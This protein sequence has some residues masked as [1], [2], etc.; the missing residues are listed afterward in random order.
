M[1]LFLKLVPFAMICTAPVLPGGTITLRPKAQNPVG[2]TQ[3][4]SFHWPPAGM[5]CNSL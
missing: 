2:V 4:L 3:K 5:L 1:G